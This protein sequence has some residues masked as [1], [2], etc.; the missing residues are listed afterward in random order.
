MLKR[1]Y[2]ITHMNFYN[3]PPKLGIFAVHN[4]VDKV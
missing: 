1:N 3:L 4:Q 2:V